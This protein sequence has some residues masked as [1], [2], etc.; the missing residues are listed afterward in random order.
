MKNNEKVVC[1]AAF[2]D[3]EDCEMAEYNGGAVATFLSTTTL[4]CVSV[5]VIIS[6]GV[7]LVVTVFSD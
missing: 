3:L 1:G 5:S 6:G 4:P 2:E 7:S